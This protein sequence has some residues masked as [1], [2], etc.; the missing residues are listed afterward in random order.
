MKNTGQFLAFDEEWFE[1][2]QRI[3]LWLLNSP[4]K[5][6]F[7]WVMRIDTTKEIYAI[8]PN[9]F[10]F[11]LK[12]N[13]IT[14]DFRTHNKFSKR[15]YYAFRPLWWAIHLWDWLVADRFIP[16][17]SYG[18]A[19]LTAYPD[20]NVEVTTVD[21]IAGNDDAPYA[22]SHDAASGSSANDSASSSNLYRQRNSGGTYFID[23]GIFLFDTSSLT[24]LATISAATISFKV[25]LKADPDVDSLSIVTSN[26]ASNT[27]VTA[28][29]FNKVGNAITSPTKQATDVPTSGI[30]ASG[31]VYT[32]IALN[33]TGIGNVSKTSITKFGTR[34]AQDCS[35]TAPTG[36]NFLVAYFADETGTTSDPKLVVTYS[37]GGSF[38][39][40]IKLRQ[41]V[42]RASNY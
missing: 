7:R 25:N 3:L 33:A 19:A 13:Q 39:P 35:K 27:A 1:K 42:I 12:G 5:K 18:F 16:I 37:A 21:G 14:V 2:N 22:T 29:D 11:D 40:F 30:D 10:Y 20:P 26:P 8:G 36:N 17:L 23:R 31:T 9:R 15:L 24:A 6:W 4:V 38:P 34:S 28:A 32:D 41:A